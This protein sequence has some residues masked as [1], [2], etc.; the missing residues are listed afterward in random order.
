[1]KEGRVVLITGGSRSGKSRFAQRLALEW[2]FPVI[3][4]ATASAEDEEMKIRIKKHQQSRPSDWRTIEEKNDLIGVL[5]SL[6]EVSTVI[7]DC[8]TLWI[9]NL[10][11]QG[12]KDEEILERAQR[13]KEFISTSDHRVILIT[14][15]VG[16]GIV[17]AS[18]LGRRFR[19]LQG[20][21][22]QIMAEGADEVY[23]M[24]SGLP[25]KIK[26]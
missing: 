2:S 15:E 18:K 14:N 8:L 24:V 5:T 7:I 10:L 12:L 19:D 17:P 21:V 16:W 20:M 26:P 6:R 13:L 11:F 1:M 23:L 9:S 22:N 4:L 25:L 3:Y